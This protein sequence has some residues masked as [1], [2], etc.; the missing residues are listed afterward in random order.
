MENANTWRKLTA[1]HYH[2]FSLHLLCYRFYF[3]LLYSPAKLLCSA[4][5]FKHNQVY[6]RF[7]VNIEQM[8]THWRLTGLSNSITSWAFDKVLPHA[9]ELY[10]DSQ[11]QEVHCCTCI[12]Q[13]TLTSWQAKTIVSNP[14]AITNRKYL[15]VDGLVVVF[16]TVKDVEVGFG[17]NV[18]LRNN[19]ITG[20]KSSWSPEAT[21][22]RK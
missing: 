21:L 16:V 20:E 7:Y 13:P 12:N 2:S 22:K 1:K 5:L 9:C 19:S 15:T 11:R 17:A 10:W 8:L 3:E 6:M 14:F 18:I 4:H